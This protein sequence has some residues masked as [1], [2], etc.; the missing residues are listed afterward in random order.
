LKTELTV[1]WT[2]E[3]LGVYSFTTEFWDVVHVATGHRC[4]KRW[5]WLG[6]SVDEELAI[7]QWADA[8]APGTYVSW[9]TWSHPQLGTVELGGPNY[10]VLKENPPPH[11]LKAEVVPHA[12]FALKHAMMSPRLEILMFTATNLGKHQQDESQNIW[13]IRVG[14]IINIKMISPLYNSCWSVCRYRQYWISAYASYCSC[15]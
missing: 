6:H 2:V 9:Y 4:S 8:N 10:F 7:A 1:H 13:Q 11:L 14:K 15:G 3:H 5:W 12:E